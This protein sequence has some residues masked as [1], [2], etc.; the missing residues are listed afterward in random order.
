[1]VDGDCIWHPYLNQSTGA[2]SPYIRE[3][4]SEGYG[5]Y[6]LRYAESLI[7]RPNSFEATRDFDALLRE[8][9]DDRNVSFAF[10]AQELDTIRKALAE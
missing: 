5:P 2:S 1:V 3:S 8:L 6:I 7:T 10:T 4:V 9:T